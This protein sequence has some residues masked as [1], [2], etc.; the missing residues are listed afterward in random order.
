MG[1][2]VS[3][4]LNLVDIVRTFAEVEA[5]EE[6][7]LDKCMYSLDANEMDCCNLLHMMNLMNVTEQL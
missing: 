7:V 6:T 4:Y 1:I 3:M 2:I 5:G